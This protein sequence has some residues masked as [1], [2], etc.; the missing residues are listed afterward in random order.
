MAV[1]SALFKVLNPALVP[2]PIP[3]FSTSVGISS[4]FAPISLKETGMPI[5]DKKFLNAL[6]PAYYAAK[7]L[8]CGI[9]YD[10]HEIFLENPWVTRNKISK[11]VWSFFE[12]HLICRVDMVVSVSH[13]AAEYLKEKYNLQHNL[14]MLYYI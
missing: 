12:K 10:T 5:P 3:N 2:S 13:A 6:I 7:K 11:F 9:I 14:F 4:F 1:T 8:K